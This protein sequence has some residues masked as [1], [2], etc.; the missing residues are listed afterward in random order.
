MVDMMLLRSFPSDG[1][2]DAGAEALKIMICR[3]DRR[4]MSQHDLSSVTCREITPKAGC[5]R[6][7]AW[8]RSGVGRDAAI[9]PAQLAPSVQ[10]GYT[11]KAP[12]PCSAAAACRAQRSHPTCRIRSERRSPTSP[13]VSTAPVRLWGGTSG[14]GR[15]QRRWSGRS[16]RAGQRGTHQQYHRHHIWHTLS[17]CTWRGR[18]RPHRPAGRARLDARPGGAPP[19]RAQ[20]P[21]LHV[22]GGPLTFSQSRGPAPHMVGRDVWTGRG[23]G[24][25]GGGLRLRGGIRASRPTS[26]DA[27]GEQPSAG[28][29]PGFAVT[30]QVLNSH[31]SMSV[32]DDLLGHL[33]YEVSVLRLDRSA[34]GPHVG[35][36]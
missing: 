34:G 5:D 8:P 18:G 25:L 4:V 36:I 23:A 31:P 22:V 3:C 30:S 17:P 26:G 32:L 12:S 20:C 35:Q 6:P 11:R 33:Y 7:K 19:R 16:A 21:G 27:K 9:P 2:D 10:G 24:A 28:P 14:P 13:V 15:R 29:Y 1:F